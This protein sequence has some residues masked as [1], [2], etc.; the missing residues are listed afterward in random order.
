ML[1]WQ[2]GDENLKKMR[3]GGV[4]QLAGHLIGLQEAVG[5]GSRTESEVDHD[6]N[7]SIVEQSQED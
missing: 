5:L 3:V 6:Y 7:P 1:K 4:A 2:N